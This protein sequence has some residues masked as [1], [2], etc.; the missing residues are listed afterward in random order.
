MASNESFDNVPRDLE[1]LTGLKIG[2]STV[3]RKAL[4]FEIP[5][6]QTK[7]VVKALA[8]DGGNVRVRTPL[9]RTICM[10]K[11]QSNTNL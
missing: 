7:K 3:H 9:L 1:Q 8:L 4:S 2:K 11:L 5:E 6:I 10:E